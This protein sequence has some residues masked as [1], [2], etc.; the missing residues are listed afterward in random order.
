MIGCDSYICI[1]VYVYIYIYTHIHIDIYLYIFIYI[2][3]YVTLVQNAHS[4]AE[5]HTTHMC[6]RA[7]WKS[8]DDR[9]KNE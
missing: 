9:N 3:I 2:Y 6:Y 8:H 7:N 4:L 1:Y 5:T